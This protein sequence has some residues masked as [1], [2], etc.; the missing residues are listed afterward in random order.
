[1]VSCTV[2][3][4]IKD[5]D[6][7]KVIRF[8]DFSEFEKFL[9]QLSE[10][11]NRKPDKSEE[12]PKG[13]QLLSPAIYKTGTKRANANVLYWDEVAFIDIDEYEGTFESVIDSF[14]DC[15]YVCYSTASSRIDHPKFRL[16]FPL[17]EAVPAEKLRHFWYALNSEFLGLVDAQTKDYSRMFYVPG[18][19]PDAFNFIFSKKGDIIDPDTLMQ[20][21]PMIERIRKNLS[22]FL[23]PEMKEKLFSMKR[24]NLSSSYS[25]TSYRDCPFVNQTLITE[26]LAITGS[27]W[28]H[29]MYTI[30]CSIASIALKK[31]Y[32]IKA[33]EIETLCREL[34]RDTGE[35]Y[36]T[37]DMKSE[38]ERAL[39]W[40]YENS[41]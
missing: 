1:M 19:Y 20:K 6:T 3:S 36:K 30:M 35:W 39:L 26:Y 8:S 12:F 7:S 18:K 38:A 41:I 25:W 13:A 23:T 24:D 16:V 28:Y 4:S 17:A 29:K 22:D 34:D 5:T 33:E 14:G 15:S 31:G 10:I 2:F 37:R 9:Y 27:G 21:H 32:D 11:P 40:A